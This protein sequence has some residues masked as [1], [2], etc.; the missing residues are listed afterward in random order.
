MEIFIALNKI[1]FNV[2]KVP[3]ASG[4]YLVS[5]NTHPHNRVQRI[6]EEWDIPITVHRLGI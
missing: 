2:K 6:Y 4:G 3:I 5:K 1:Q